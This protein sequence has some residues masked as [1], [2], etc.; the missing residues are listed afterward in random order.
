MYYLFS[1]NTEQFKSVIFNI[2][3]LSDTNAFFQASLDSL[4]QSLHSSGHGFPILRGCDLASS[5][6]QFDQE[7]FDLLTKRKGVY[8]YE[9]VILFARFCCTSNRH[10]SQVVT[11]A[12]LVL[13][14]I[15]PSQ[16]LMMPLASPRARHFFRR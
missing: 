16:N 14:T 6:G 8:P 3:R 5:E 13:G 10:T 9:Y 12:P 4:V 1:V 2:F 15:T 7:K 11:T